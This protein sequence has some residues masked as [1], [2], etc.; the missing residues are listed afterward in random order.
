MRNH[1][2]KIRFCHKLEIDNEHL[3]PD[4]IAG[5]HL[6]GYCLCFAGQSPAAASLKAT[7]CRHHV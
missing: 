4:I 5:C 2:L 7:V 1:S 6:P 3:S